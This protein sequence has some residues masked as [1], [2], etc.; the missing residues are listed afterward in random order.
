MTDN[1][2]DSD[3]GS[4]SDSDSDNNNDNDNNSFI[5]VSTCLV[6]T[7]KWGHKKIKITHI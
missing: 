2:S 7:T 3:S 5:E 1:D 6:F 4:G